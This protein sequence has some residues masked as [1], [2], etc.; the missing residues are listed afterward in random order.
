MLHADKSN[1]S[2][3]TQKNNSIHKVNLTTNISKVWE[4]SNPGPAKV[5]KDSTCISAGWNLFSTIEKGVVLVL[6]KKHAPWQ[7][8]CGVELALVRLMVQ[9]TQSHGQPCLQLSKSFCFSSP[10]TVKPSWLVICLS[11]SS[12]RFTRDWL[13]GR[14]TTT[15]TITGTRQ[16]LSNSFL[17][18]GAKATHPLRSHIIQISVLSRVQFYTHSSSGEI[19]LQQHNMEKEWPLHGSRHYTTAHSTTT[20]KRK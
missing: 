12:G 11:Q 15:S 2:W 8:H 7:H 16:T 3:C 5:K 4:G 14:R 9:S 10:Q 1:L 13:R 20:V 19:V 6:P 18:Q 17:W